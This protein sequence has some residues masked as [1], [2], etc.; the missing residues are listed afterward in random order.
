M[1]NHA[2]ELVVVQVVRVLWKEFCERN[3]RELEEYDAYKRNNSRHA[4][5]PPSFL[6]SYA[7]GLRPGKFI[8]SK[9]EAR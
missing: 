2:G 4:P 9:N 3:W 6:Q 7:K 8:G 5:A 1:A